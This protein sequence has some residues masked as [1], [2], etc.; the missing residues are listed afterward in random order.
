M[1]ANHTALPKKST[2]VLLAESLLAE[3]TDLGI[4]VSQAAEAGLVKAVADR[5]AEVWMEQNTGAIASSNDYVEKHG[6]PLPQ[7]RNF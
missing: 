1:A 3:A 7:F 4:N 5:R 6:L 2:Y